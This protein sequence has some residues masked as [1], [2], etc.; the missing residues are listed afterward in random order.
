M[1]VLMKWSANARLQMTRCSD[2]TETS[3]FRTVKCIRK[4]VLL[5][6]LT[7]WNF[8]GHRRRWGAWRSEQPVQQ[9]RRPRVLRLRMSEHQR[10]RKALSRRNSRSQ[11]RYQGEHV[12]LLFFITTIASYLS[13]TIGVICFKLVYVDVNGVTFSIVLYWFRCRLRVSHYQ[14]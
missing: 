6:F 14:F 9:Q 10:Y 8:S 13:S 12:K 3:F 2:C 4:F 5:I 7:Q 11:W 1:S